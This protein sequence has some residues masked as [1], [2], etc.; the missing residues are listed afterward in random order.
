MLRNLIFADRLQ[1]A[2]NYLKNLN[3][4][5]CFSILNEAWNSLKNSTLEK[6]WKHLLG[7]L[8]QPANC[9]QSSVASE[10]SNNFPQLETN[11]ADAD[12]VL[13]NIR[14]PPEISANLSRLSLEPNSEEVLQ[15]WFDAIDETD[16]G[17]EPMSDIDLVQFVQNNRIEETEIDVVTNSEN[18]SD[19]SSVFQTG[20]I[21]SSQAYGGLQLFQNFAL[22]KVSPEEYNKILLCLEV[23]NNILEGREPESSPQKELNSV[24]KL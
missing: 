13:E 11:E 9:R 17:W 14:I 6:V 10:S 15:N 18:S 8:C 5:D 19:S 1:G 16:C 3:Y 2:D 23:A 20:E 4:H 7:D 22:K 21:S 24:F 12:E